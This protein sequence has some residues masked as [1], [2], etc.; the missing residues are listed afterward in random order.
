MDRL[1][2][3]LPD[4]SERGRLEAPSTPPE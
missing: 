2:A 3:V 1:E 4:L